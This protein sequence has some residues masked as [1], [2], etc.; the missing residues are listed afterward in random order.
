MPTMIRDLLNR[1]DGTVI[2]IGPE[3]TMLEA[4]RT[5][6]EADISALV[7]KDGDAVVGIVSERDFARK[8]GAENK[9]PDS[10]LVR[11]AMSPAV[12]YIEPHHSVEEAMAVMTS[13]EIRHLP[14]MTDG[15][16]SGMVS[17]RDLI[18]DAIAERDFVI[19]QLERYIG[20]DLASR[21][22]QPV[23]VTLRPRAAV[24]SGTAGSA[25]GL[26]LGTGPGRGSARRP[27]GGAARRD[28]LPSP[29][30]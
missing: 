16:V 30:R 15:R 6:A 28:A 5:M 8:V 26:R 18:K 24:R 23:V 4:V 11:D 7:V 17:M 22:R 1:K 19:G 20:T 29:Y 10:V 25:L 3:K 2:S 12:L 21:R 14:V 13:N 9:L 27:G